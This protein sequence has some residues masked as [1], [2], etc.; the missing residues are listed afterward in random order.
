MMPWRYLIPIAV[1]LGLIGLFWVGLR[2][3]PGRIPS[4]LIG[5]PV[6]EFSLPRLHQAE[7]LFTDDALRGQ[8]S[9]VN[10]WASWCFTCRQE[11]AVLDRLAQ[12][13]ILPIYGLDYKDAR[14]DAQAWLRRYGDPYAAIAYDPEGKVGIDWGVYGVPESYLIDAEGRIQWK[15]VGPLTQTVVERDLLPLV[16]KLR[17][18]G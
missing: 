17:E 10:V 6:P 8:V 14:R 3:D 5:K 7:S 4:P 18:Q 13:D 15:Y 12:R 11:A 2:H 9:L 1:V 16:R